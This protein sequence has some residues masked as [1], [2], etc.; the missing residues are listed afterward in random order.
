MALYWGLHLCLSFLLAFLFRFGFAL[1]PSDT[2]RDADIQQSS[3]VGGN[4][5]MDP[6]VVDSPEFGLRWKVAMNNLEQFY[7][8]PLVYT[9]SG[10]SQLVFLAS[11]QNYVRTLDAKSGAVIN[12]RQLHT[13]FLQSDIGCTDIPNTIG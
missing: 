7:A 6:A 1:D 11:S 12:S 3:Y 9:P 4:H 13:P 2:W 10:G 5:N 8:K